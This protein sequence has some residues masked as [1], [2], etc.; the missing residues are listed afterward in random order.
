M[1]SRFVWRREVQKNVLVKEK[2]EGGI[3]GGWDS[4]Y[5]SVAPL[6]FFTLQKT[7]KS[8]PS[9][10]KNLKYVVTMIAFKG[11]RFTDNTMSGSNVEHGS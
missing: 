2:E 6:P 7:H 11:L 1:P 9:G 4:S 8:G 10:P 3:S 5:K